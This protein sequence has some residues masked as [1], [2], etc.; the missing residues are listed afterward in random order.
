MFYYRHRLVMAVDENIT[1]GGWQHESCWVPDIY[2]YNSSIRD[3]YIQLSMTVAI[4]MTSSD[5]TP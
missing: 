2:F 3:E 4:V 5:I 1:I